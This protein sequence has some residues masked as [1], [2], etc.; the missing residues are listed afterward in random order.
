MHQGQIS[1]D[2]ESKIRIQNAEYLSETDWDYLTPCETVP[3][4]LYQRPSAW[5]SEIAF[6]LET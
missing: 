4:I 2:Q 3:E 1:K 5:I 6:R